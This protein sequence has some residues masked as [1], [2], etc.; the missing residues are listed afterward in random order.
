MYGD[1]GAALTTT[2]FALNTLKTLNALS[3]ISSG[4]VSETIFFC[5]ISSSPV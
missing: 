1:V 3:K 4:T 2:L 5:M